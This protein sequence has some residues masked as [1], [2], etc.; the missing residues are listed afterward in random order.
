VKRLHILTLISAVAVSGLI[1]VG[2]VSAEDNGSSNASGES[3]QEVHNPKGNML[4]EVS[5]DHQTHGDQAH[6][7]AAAASTAAN[8]L[9]YHNGPVMDV[10]QTF[11]IFWTDATHPFSQTTQNIVTQYLSDL[12]VQPSANVYASTTQYYSQTTKTATITKATTALI[13]GVQTNTYTSNNTFV[14]GDIVT[15]TRVKSTSTST[16][17]WYNIT[18]PVLSAI[19]TSFT[20]K[21]TGTGAQ[22][23]SSSGTATAAAQ[24]TMIRN[25]SSFNP[26]NNVFLDSQP[27]PASGCSFSGQPG[28]N[29]CLS[30]AQLQTELKRVMALKG[31]TGDNHKL[32]FIYTGKGVGSCSGTSCSYTAYCAYHSWIGT[33]TSAT[34]YANMPYADDINGCASGTSPNNDIA[35]DGLVNLTSHEHAEAITD[36]TGTG[37]YA[38]TGYENGDNCAWYFGTP[39]N[40]SIGTNLAI[41]KV[42]PAT[43]GTT[44]RSGYVTYTAANTFK[45][46]Q[47]V[48]I[49]GIGAT[50]NG[51]FMVA[52]A[53][54]TTF[55]VGNSST[56]TGY[57]NTGNAGVLNPNWYNQTINGHFYAM[58]LEWSNAANN[59]TGGC[60]ATTLLN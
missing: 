11:A 35:G 15:V 55:T 27:F 20:L 50:Y 47:M 29:L 10:N 59:N 31:W 43:V 54:S 53:T 21:A 58:Q 38:S 1:A 60:V 46:G 49:S 7:F 51:F 5:S 25:A 44:A 4:G 19:P 14:A 16:S 40:Y 52:A 28:V 30:D 26:A 6:T 13:G 17:T 3:S 23:Y 34:L 56:A 22:T 41:T 57:S 2:P 33:G 8:Q 24:K 39:T 32:Y 36:P 37:W 12:T 45:V 42:S 9:A 18:G 48:Q